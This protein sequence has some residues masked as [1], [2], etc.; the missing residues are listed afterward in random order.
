VEHRGV[1]ATKTV[2][3]TATRV[4]VAKTASITLQPNPLASFTLSGNRVI[5]G[6]TARVFGTVAITHPVGVNTPISLTTSDRTGAP[7]PATVT[8]PSGAKSVTVEILHGDVAALSAAKLRAQ[9]QDQ[10]IEQTLEVFPNRLVSI[11]ASPTDFVGG[12][13]T[14]VSVRVELLYAVRDATVL[15]FS[16]SDPNAVE[17]PGSWA[18]PAGSNVLTISATHRTVPA[19]KSVSLSVRKL[20]HVR[21]TAVMVRRGL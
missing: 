13:S 10:S 16:S 20:G 11:Q 9:W 12:S 21:T 19:D 2:P 14:P 7:V 4:G 6:S 15:E 18:V 3:I 5:G 8:I 1:P 17:L